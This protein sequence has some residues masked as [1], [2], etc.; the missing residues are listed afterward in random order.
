MA[1]RDLFVDFESGSVSSTTGSVKSKVDRYAERILNRVR[2]GEGRGAGV[3]VISG[4][5]R[6]MSFSRCGKRCGHSGRI[7]GGRSGWPGGGRMLLAIWRKIR[8]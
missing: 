8:T 3:E 7:G 2:T 6:L 1:R 4:W 5:G